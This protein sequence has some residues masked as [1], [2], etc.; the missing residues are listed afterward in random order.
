MINEVPFYHYEYAFL[1]DR[2]NYAR[3]KVMSD[4]SEYAVLS[5]NEGDEEGYS[6]R[7]DIRG[8][9]DSKDSVEEI[10][11]YAKAKLP[12]EFSSIDEILGKLIEISRQYPEKE[13]YENRTDTEYYGFEKQ[14][15]AE[16]SD[17]RLVACR[18]W[19]YTAYL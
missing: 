11:A 1:Q 4:K 17:T 9:S 16:K 18:V 14:V 19:V 13:K 2:L 12:D 5:I 8:N 15:V 7:L 6:R 3:N 10:V